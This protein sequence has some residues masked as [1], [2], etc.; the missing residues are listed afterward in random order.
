MQGPWMMVVLALALAGVPGRAQPEVAQQEV[1]LAEPPDLAELLRQAEH[2]LLLREDLLQLHADQGD[3]ESEFQISQPRW[4]SKRQHPGKREAAEEEEGMAEEEE[5]EAG[6]VGP[7]KRQH[8]GRREDAPAGSVD[9]PQQKRQHPGRR[10]SWL[11]DMVTKRQH[12]GR[13]LAELQAQEGAEKEEEEG[14]EEEGERGTEKRQ[15]PGKRALGGACGPWRA[16]GQ[17][18]LLL[19]LLA[20]LGRDGVAESKRQHPGRRATLQA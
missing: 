19:G 2:L 10:S 5:E 17:A 18:R 9:A 3:A 11:R 1:G 6:A 12:P 13:R 7:V 14:E 8:P 20:G 16:C 15:H 4:V